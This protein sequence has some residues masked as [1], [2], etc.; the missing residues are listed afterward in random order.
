MAAGDFIHACGLTVMEKVVP[1]CQPEN[2]HGYA[3]RP[4]IFY[5]A[6]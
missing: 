5:R 3:L 4:F 1:P 6:E 2:E